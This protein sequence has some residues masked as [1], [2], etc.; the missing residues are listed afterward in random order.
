[1]TL[2]EQLDTIGL[3]AVGEDLDDILAHAAKRR[4]SHT[5][6]LEHL[7]ALETK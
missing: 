4:W 1:M 3:K 6:L 2:H 5:Q 7:V